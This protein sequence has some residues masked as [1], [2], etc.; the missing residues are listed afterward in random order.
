M[1]GKL[2][3]YIALIFSTV[4]TLFYFLA[5]KNKKY[6]KIAEI[7]YWALFAAI[8]LASA[9]LLSNI[10]SYNFQYY[11][12]WSYSSKELP[13]GLLITSFYS[14]QEGSILLWALMMAALGFFVQ[15]YAKK[16][17]YQELVMGL[18]SLVIVFLSLMLISKSPFE[19]IWEAFADSGTPVG[20]TPPN[21]R[22]L[23]PILQNYWNAIHPPIVF[24]GYAMM[25]IPFIFA[26][27]GLWRREYHRW[28]DISLPWTLA[29]TGVLGLGIMLGG[30]WA[31]E[32]LGWGGFWGWDPV[33]NASLLPWLVAVALVHTMLV[34]RRTKG[35]VRTN[36]V[37]SILAF[38][39]VLFAT[40]LTRSG[41]LGD[42]SVHSFGE[43]GKFIYSLLIISLIVF[44]LIGIVSLLIRAKEISSISGA[45]DFKF[46]S[47]EF[48]LSLGSI[49]ILAIAIIVFI[50]TNWPLF[51]EIAGSQKSSVDISFYDKW[52]LPFAILLLLTSAFSLYL[53]WNSTDLKNKINR[54]AISLSI[55]IIFSLI[56]FWQGIN[57]VPYLLLA[58]AAI[59]TIVVNLE[60]IIRNWKSYKHGFGTYLSHMGVAFLLL[61][62]LLSGAYSTTQHITLAVGSSTEALGYKLTFKEVNQIEKHFQDREKYEFIV[63]A[64][65]DG[66]SIELK[67]IF[68]WS[69]FN[70]RMAP[71]LEPGIKEKL[72]Y[73]VYIS[74]KATEN[75]SNA[76]MVLLTREETAKVPLDTSIKI[77]LLG[78][79]MNH[80][81]EMTVDN[82][83]RLGVAVEFNK[84]GDKYIDTL[85]SAIDINT[86]TGNPEP[87]LIKGTSIKVGFSELIASMQGGSQAAF[88][89]LREGEEPPKQTQVFT[90]DFAIKPFINFV[91]L[92]TILIV[93]G[94]F[95][96]IFRHRRENISQ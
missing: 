90:F 50:G 77:T 96:A 20:F 1:I 28:I 34:Q 5:L 71:F 78:F 29:A 36:F 86:K 39:L 65:K 81:M 54:I 84:S 57:V 95:W 13:L 17:G 35:L 43:P 75:R 72:F 87:K 4:S 68:Y 7:S 63:T 2:S 92:G 46:N 24:A 67:P 69:D 70:Q 26:V 3:I 12:I 53:H 82:R 40:F 31:Y 93:V 19:Y 89:F 45:I 11:Y 55:S 56:A 59:Y 22:G 51:S 41:V 25:S 80:A 15:P 48:F 27:A 30:F 62:A 76:P 64:E 74:P 79:D 85:Y 32:V 49:I 33:E 6:I 61:G 9:F 91:W 10:L 52:N 8:V 23:N 94:F 21:G 38:I 18:Y 14:G 47:R 37:L 44:F 66:K 42:I 58:F 83:V 73:D 88:V 16:H 60:F